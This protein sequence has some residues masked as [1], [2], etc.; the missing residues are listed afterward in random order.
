MQSSVYRRRWWTL[1]TI[2]VSVLVVILDASI[3]NIALPT[4]QRELN[5]TMSD[6]QWIVTAYTMVFAGL[7]LTTGSLGDRLG[8]ARMLQ[9][10]IVVFAAGSLLASLAGTGL[11]LI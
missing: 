5:A 11:Q 7:M 10:G 3:V 4:L 1:V 9:A 8:R 2:A 6:L